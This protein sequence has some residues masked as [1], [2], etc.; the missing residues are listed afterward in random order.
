MR[1]STA[2]ANNC[3][4][5]QGGDAVTQDR[6]GRGFAR[7]K[8]NRDCQHEKRPHGSAASTT[9]P[10]GAGAAKARA[11]VLPESHFPEA[12]GI[13]KVVG[14]GPTTLSTMIV[15]GMCCAISCPH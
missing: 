5:P 13:L 14:A 3:I 4:C 1:T 10:Q 6:S 11:W 8:T 7:H 9:F 12:C 2:E 15:G